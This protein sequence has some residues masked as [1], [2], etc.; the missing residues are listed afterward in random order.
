MVSRSLQNVLYHRHHNLSAHVIHFSIG[1][2]DSRAA[3]PTEVAEHHLVVIS[4]VDRENLGALV[5]S[6]G[7]FEIFINKRQKTILLLVDI[8][9]ES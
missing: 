5:V 2:V 9:Y 1:S 6:S 8:F 3:R 7:E 4:S